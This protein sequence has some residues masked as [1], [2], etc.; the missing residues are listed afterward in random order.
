M[1]LNQSK[2]PENNPFLLKQNNTLYKYHVINE[3]FY[4]LENKVCYTAAGS[5][6]RTRYEVPDNYLV[7]TSWERTKLCY[8]VECE[9]IYKQDG[10]VYIIRFEENSQQ[11][12]LKSK[13]SSTAV[14][15]NYLQVNVE[16]ER[17]RKKR[18]PH[19]LKLFNSLSESMKTKRSR[20][21]SIHLGKTFNKIKFNVQY[22]INYKNNDKENRD[23]LLDPFMEVIDHGPISHHAY[24]TVDTDNQEVEEEVLKYI[25]KACYRCITDIL[26]FIIPSLIG[27]GILN[28]N[29]LVINIRI[30]GDGRNVENYEI[31]KNVMDPLIIELNNLMTNRLDLMSQ[32]QKTSALGAAAPKKILEI[33]TIYIKLR[34]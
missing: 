25:S 18:Q 9:I 17:K 21:F 5:C 1:S 20:A 13:K 30:L 34:K 10:P 33:R 28:T 2:Y 3:G 24:Y 22:I 26:M 23:R 27:R 15:N 31:L 11:Y 7:Q 14:A 12:A 4:P 6:N 19:S 32:I 16:Q 29:N 8:I